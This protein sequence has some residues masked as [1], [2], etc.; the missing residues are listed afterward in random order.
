MQLHSEERKVN[1]MAKPQAN[2]N[3]FRPNENEL[4]TINNFPPYWKPEEG[5]SFYAAPVG[6]D[7]RDPKFPRVV[8][9]A[10]EPIEC[11]TGASDNQENVTVERGGLFTSSEYGS[12]RVAIVDAVMG[13]PVIVTVEDE[14]GTNE[15]GEFY[16]FQYQYSLADAKAIK[17]G[18]ASPMLAQ[19]NAAKAELVTAQA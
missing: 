7:Y 2:K 9:K 5:K 11:F 13:Y 14:M 3:T 8:W 10:L 19:V 15:R 17:A 1:P 18:I 6:K 4:T 12:M 16:R